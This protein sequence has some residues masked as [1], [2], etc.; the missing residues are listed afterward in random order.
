MTPLESYF[1]NHIR[2]TGPISLSYYM[3][4]CLSHPEHGYYMS[5]DP[6]GK[7]GDFITAPEISQMFGE[8]IGVWLVD[9]WRQAGSPK[10]LVLLE[11]GPGRGTLMADVL[12]AT[13]N[14]NGF[15]EAVQIKLLENSPV[16]RE[17]QKQNLRGFDMEWFSSL[18]D[19][20]IS[21][22][23]IFIV[24]NEFF[25][26]LP[27]KQFEK[28]KEGWA[29]R[30]V[31][32]D[33][34]ENL[35]LGLMPVQD[36]GA[37][38]AGL[39][40]GKIVEMS[41]SQDMLFHA[42]CN[43][44]KKNGGALLSIDYGYLN[45]CGDTL[46]AVKKHQKVGIFETPGQ[47]DLTA[48]IDFQKFIESASKINMHICNVKTQG[49]FLKNLGIGLRASV[50]RSN[51]NSNQAKLIDSSV[52]RLCDTDEMGALFKVMC[53]HSEINKIKLKPAGF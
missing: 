53:V 43:L 46:Q 32:I 8:L 7:E 11:C 50:L 38:P 33:E 22:A 34:D 9:L 27:I 1:I 29:E 24:A 10:E 16:L 37:M 36:Y 30:C 44:I 18:E 49:E 35:T 48:H 6:F 52:K 42:L 2:E 40:N 39:S 17:K 5:G 23:P 3:E 21:Q 31:G 19:I 14:V 13:K 26:A 47:S 12:R 41:P 20:N 28:V 45:G 4:L 15:H 51:A 25:D